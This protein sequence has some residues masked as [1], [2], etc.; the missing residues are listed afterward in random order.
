MRVTVKLVV[1][2]MLGMAIVTG[3][4]L[5]WVNARETEEFYRRTNAD[6]VRQGEFVAS[7]LIKIWQTE[8][9][10]GALRF[11]E[12][13]QQ[14][15]DDL[16]I[17]WVRFGV[18]T[19]PYRPLAPADE[20]PPA[21]QPGQTRPLIVTAEETRYVCHY[22][23][24]DVPGEPAGGLEIAKP[25]TVLDNTKREFFSQVLAWMGSSVLAS[26]ILMAF[27]G[28]R[29]VGRPLKQLAQQSR[30]FAAGNLTARAE[31]SSK[32]EIGQLAKSFNI[33]CDALQSSQHRA[34]AEAAARLTATEQLRHADRLKTVGRL[35]AG[36]AHELGTPLNVVA[37]RAQLIASGKLT[38]TEIVSSAE[39]I[40]QEAHRMTS[41]IRQLLD[42]A[43][44][45]TPHRASVDVRHVVDHTAKLLESLAKK[46]NT[47]IPVHACDTP[48]LA[49]IDAGQIEQVLT[50]LL[51]NAIQAT[52]SG[53]HVQI[54]VTQRQLTPPDQP[55]APARDYVCVAVRDEGTGISEADR[56]HLFEP[57]FTTRPMGEGTGLGLSISYGIAQEH[58]GYI[59]VQSKQ[60]EGSC[61]TVYLPVGGAA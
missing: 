57:F 36:V 2:F 31:V 45:R 41:I 21:Q 11:L 34:A 1:A 16:R 33:M 26:G 13:Y 27:I 61:F 14:S 24:V 60:G 18:E 52:P 25:M 3:I 59:D 53:G 35:A 51:V 38:E 5:W 32:D 4:S 49:E 9:R 8:G 42:F 54:D 29:F 6:A 30:E 58:G 10:R 23:P 47:S 12:N 55:D 28:M 37:G 20:I 50:N 39:T 19:G 40:R 22:W 15:E 17:S 7:V 44:C 56:P 48:C 46:R 43:R